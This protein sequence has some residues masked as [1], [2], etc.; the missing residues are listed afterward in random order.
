MASVKTWKSPVLLIQGG[1]DTLFP[2]PS[3]RDQ[4][5]LFT[6]SQSVTYADL[7]DAGHALTYETG[8]I[9]LA[10]IVARFLSRNGL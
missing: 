10:D 1:R 2:P 7:P 3:V 4:A 6:G 5:S 9:R 8:H